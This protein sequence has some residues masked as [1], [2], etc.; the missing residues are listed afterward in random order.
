MLPGNG[1]GR[2]RSR[3][4]IAVTSLAALT[5]L[6]VA[7]GLRAPDFLTYRY[8]VQ[9]AEHGIDVYVVNVSGPGLKG[10]PFTYTPF[11]AVALWPTTI[12][13][14]TSAYLIWCAASM[15]VL[16]AVL[17]RFVPAT[18]RRRPAVVALVIGVAATTCIVR[19][20]VDQG[21]INVLLMGLCL[22]DLFRRDRTGPAGWL[23]RG[24]LVGV[25]TAIKLTPGLFIV[26]FL[27]TRQWRLARAA[28][29]GAAGATAIG[30]VAHPAM[31]ITFFRSALWSL[32]DR[33][34]LGHPVAFT[35][36]NSIGGL[37]ESCGR[38][39]HPVVLPLVLAAA[40]VGL[41]AAARTHRA[42]REPDAWLIVGLT[43]AVV[44]PF[45]WTHHLVYLLPALTTLAITR[46]W[47]RRPTGIIAA[48][49]IVAVLHFG[50]PSPLMRAFL[51]GLCVAAVIALRATA[52][53][54]G[55]NSGT[56]LRVWRGAVR[57][58]A[59]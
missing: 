52:P 15:V 48:A 32:Q 23:P 57:T 45:T 27:L 49:L 40:G 11:G 35:G 7:H 42:G 1:A 9:A 38:W 25:A 21:Q 5:A 59:K 3:A 58:L 37:L 10:Q 44:S 8:G 51:V 22:G 14:W 4:A 18:T 43:A 56:S 28:V 47:A 34:D 2:H 6:L 29:A 33:V 26:Y 12:L 13:N 53:I 39:A 36:N 46:S 24:V 17:A 55:A 20:N 54:P 19:Q 31:T 16:G 30:A 41:L 50:L